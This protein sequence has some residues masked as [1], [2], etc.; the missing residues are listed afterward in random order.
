MRKNKTGHP[1]DD[2]SPVSFLLLFKKICLFRVKFGGCAP[3]G[4][5]LQTTLSGGVWFLKAGLIRFAHMQRERARLLIIC[6][7]SKIRVN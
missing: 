6:K 2:S 7:N 4:S 1:M 3:K 5:F